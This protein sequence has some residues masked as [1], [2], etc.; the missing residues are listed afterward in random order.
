MTG[1]IG[2]GREQEA[3]I[4][5]GMHKNAHSAHGIKNESSRGR[6]REKCTITLI[7]YH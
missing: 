1:K 7:L 3:E 4:L 2:R 5:Y 6:G